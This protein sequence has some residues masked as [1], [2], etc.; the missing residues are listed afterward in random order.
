M[1]NKTPSRNPFEENVKSFSIN[2]KNFKWKIMQYNKKVLPLSQYFSVFGI[3]KKK[4]WFYVFSS[5][6]VFLMFW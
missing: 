2:H 1:L 5:V 6:Y 4:L 3:A